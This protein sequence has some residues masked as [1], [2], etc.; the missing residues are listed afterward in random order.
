MKKL[1]TAEK[2]VAYI[3]NHSK[4]MTASCNGDEVILATELGEFTLCQEDKLYLADRF[5]HERT[6]YRVMTF[7]DLALTCYEELEQGIRKRDFTHL[8]NAEEGLKYLSERLH[9]ELRNTFRAGTIFE[10]TGWRHFH[11]DETFLRFVGR[12][13]PSISKENITAIIEQI[14]DVRD[15]YVGDGDVDEALKSIL[16]TIR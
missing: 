8:D 12:I 6:W 16:P 5:D 4:T 1:T 7:P 15:R 2:A 3:A 10:S 11:E 13:N 14:F 9:R